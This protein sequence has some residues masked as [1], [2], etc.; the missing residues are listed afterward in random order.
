MPTVLEKHRELL[1]AADINTSQEVHP[2]TICNRCYLTLRKLEE[3]DA[4]GDIRET[5]LSPFKWVPHGDAERPVCEHFQ[6]SQQGAMTCPAPV[7]IS[8]T[9][10][11]Q[12]P[13]LS[14]DTHRR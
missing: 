7:K 8:H 6:A 3:A 2:I 12:I 9:N 13:K 10:C 14:P 4:S 11:H 5:A 1:A